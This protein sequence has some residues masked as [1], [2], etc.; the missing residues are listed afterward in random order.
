MVPSRA[1]PARA[2]RWKSLARTP[3][4]MPGPWSSTS[5]TMAGGSSR[6]APA[7][8][9]VLAAEYLSALPS[10]LRTAR[11]H[12][13]H[14]HQR[15]ACAA[16]A[17]DADAR[18]A[19]RSR[20]TRQTAIRVSMSV[21]CAAT[22]A[23]PA[24]GAAKVLS[25][26]PQHLADDGLGPGQAFAQHGGGLAFEGR[27]WRF[28]APALALLSGRR[29]SWA[30]V[31][32]L[33][34]LV[35]RA[36]QLFGMVFDLGAQAAFACQFALAAQVVGHVHREAKARSAGAGRR[37]RWWPTSARR[38]CPSAQRGARPARWPPSCHSS[39]NWRTIS[40]AAL[41]AGM[42]AASGRPTDLVPRVASMA[43][44]GFTD[45]EQVAHRV[46]TEWSRAGVDS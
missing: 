4:A 27:C 33:R 42:K 17:F 35:Q 46:S 7:A 43:Q 31:E 19:S 30:S 21:S 14:V 1:C 16:L 3:S 37:A 26:P 39:G 25:T 6:P 28:A 44:P 13:A 23:A 20:S 38:N 8:T 41:S 40:A 22:D 9:G 45:R 29:T 36:P 34:A 10:R 32:H 2:P 24:A 15:G 12:Q 18:R 11:A 5:N